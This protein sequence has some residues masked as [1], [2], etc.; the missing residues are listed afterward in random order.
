MVLSRQ[1]VRLSKFQLLGITTLFM[2][3]KMEEMDVQ[4]AP[5]FAKYTSDFCSATEIC[6]REKEVVSLLKWRL[7]PDTLYFWL[8]YFVRAWDQFVVLQGLNS[9]FSFKNKKAATTP[10]GPVRG[11]LGLD[12]REF[13]STASEKNQSFYHA[14]D[15]FSLENKD[16][17]YRRLIQALDLMTLDSKMH[18]MKRHALALAVLVVG[19]MQRNGILDLQGDVNIEELQ[20]TLE[21]FISSNQDLALQIRF[22]ELIETFL[23][24]FC[25]EICTDL[26]IV[27][28]VRQELSTPAKKSTKN[29]A[30][31]ATQDKL[32][33]RRISREILYAVRFFTVETQ[34]SKPQFRRSRRSVTLETTQLVNGNP[35]QV[36]EIRCVNDPF[37]TKED[38]LG[39]HIHTKNALKSLKKFLFQP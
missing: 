36:S 12:E 5:K 15:H 33:I 22:L 27:P 8:E 30:I 10:A 23:A 1:V 4:I 25:P 29:P 24:R 31:A 7:N 35:Q 18:K 28:G 26:G 21:E 17:G 13:L 11:P 38:Y 39:T 20:V 19:L 3:A 34:F 2:A 16:N 37:I 32:W 14:S 6:S 9:H